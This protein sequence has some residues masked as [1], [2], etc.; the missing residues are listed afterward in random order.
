MYV[1]LYTCYFS[2][3]GDFVL[4]YWTKED[5][6]SVLEEKKIT[7]GKLQGVIVTWSLERPC[8]PFELLLLVSMHV[9]LTNKKRDGGVGEMVFRWKSHTV[10]C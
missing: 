6:A 8:I 10:Q 9:M 1:V 4:V 5:S 3:L 7:G 2:P